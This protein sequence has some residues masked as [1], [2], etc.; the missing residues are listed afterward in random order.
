MSDLEDDEN[1][2]AGQEEDD[3]E[4]MKAALFGDENDEEEE[5]DYYGAANADRKAALQR[6]SKRKRD[7]EQ[8][9]EGEV[10]E[11][12]VARSVARKNRADEE[13]EEE[14]DITLPNED[15][16]AFIDDDGVPQDEVDQDE[17]L[18]GGYQSEAEEDNEPEDDGLP[19]GK[20]KKK[21]NK[22]KDED[23]DGKVNMLI[24]R[25]EQCYEEDMNNHENKEPA[26]SKLQAIKEVE[27]FLANRNYHRPFLQLNGLKQLANW[28]QQ[29]SDGSLPNARVRAAVLRILQDLP[30]DTTSDM[31]KDLLKQSQIGAQIMFLYKCPD[32]TPGNRRIAKELVEKWSRPIFRR[33]EDVEIRMKRDEERLRQYAAARRMQQQAEKE[34]QA[35]QE[36]K[37]SKPNE[38]GFRWHAAIPQ[39]SK[40]DYVKA[41][42]GIS[43]YQEGQ[44]GAGAKQPSR[45]AKKMREISRKNKNTTARAAKPSV[46]GR[47]LVMFH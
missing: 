17:E 47:G 38:P 6:L 15:D 10:R 7:E 44:L 9:E 41:P 33:E 4:R 39:A 46:E 25:M 45:F 40:L 23:I 34:K 13:E 20:N 19:F 43:D 22:E 11:A 27:D 3:R 29:Y 16:R 35:V 8:E 18:V 37:P 1:Y 28:L 2:M 31:I 5:G 21:R 42:E 12:P 14:E 26:F 30:I 24:A 32:E 36:Q